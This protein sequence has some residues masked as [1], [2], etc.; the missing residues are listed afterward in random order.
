MP[1]KMQ[2]KFLSNIVLLLTINLLI[3]PFWILGI[4]RTVQNTIGN[5][6]YG[7]YMV[8]FNMSLMFTM[9]LD[10]GINNYTSTFIARHKQMLDKKFAALVPLKLIFS[11][12]YLVFTLFMGL[13]YGMEGKALGLLMLLGFNQVMLFFI[14][15]FRANI[16]GLQLFKTDAW[17]SVTDRG[18]MIV[19]GLGLLLTLKGSFALEHFIMMQTLGYLCS[20]IICYVVI[21]G[22]LKKVHLSFSYPMMLSMVRQS[23]P[24]ALLAL[25][26]TI[27]MRSDILIMKKLLPDGDEQNGVYAAANRLMEAAN[28]MAGLVSAMLLPLFS[29]LIKSGEDLNGIVKLSMAILIVPAV[30]V[31]GVA[32]YYHLDV[33]LLLNKT[34]PVA[35][36]AVFKYVML[37]FVA[38]CTM[39]V[40][41]TLLTANGN[42]RTLNALAA[43]ALVINAA[44][45][46]FLQPQL[47]AQGAA[48]AMVCTHGFIALTN[49]YFAKR[50][51][52]LALQ[53]SYLLRFMLVL[54]VSFATVWICRIYLLHF[55]WAGILSGVIA[56]MMLFITRLFHVKQLRQVLQNRI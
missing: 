16:S 32:W 29:R 25:L 1:E 3:K 9:L 7:Q 44:L 51:L 36:A 42:L 4:D 21:A 8:M 38:M 46:L 11:A 40:F 37:S 2:K 22:K 56:V 6:S 53:V 30:C 52:K 39:Y 33:M 31:A 17:L 18:M 50:Y 48:I 34:S 14:M 28:M 49:L 43:V 19:F 47:G 12:A 15:Y 20:L 26:M 23:W 10:F 54:V 41:G 24:Y 27:Y 5:E 13:L 55:L 45:N 35:S